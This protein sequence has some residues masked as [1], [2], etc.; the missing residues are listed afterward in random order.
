MPFGLRRIFMNPGYPASWPPGRNACRIER[1]DRPGLL[2]YR[3]A[4]GFEGSSDAPTRPEAKFA[5]PS[6]IYSAP[7]LSLLNFPSGSLVAIEDH[8]A[9]RWHELH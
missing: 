7:Y 6:V 8:D 3:T 2:P 5:H 1:K 9:G 4:G